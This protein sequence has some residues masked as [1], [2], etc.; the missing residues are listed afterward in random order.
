METVFHCPTCNEPLHRI[1]NVQIVEF[2]EKKIEEI[3]EE[4]ET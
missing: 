2:L 3:K 4:L 1:E